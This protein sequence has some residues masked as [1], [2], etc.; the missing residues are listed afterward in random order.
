MVPQVAYR[1]K[2]TQRAEVDYSYKKLTGGSGQFA[3]VKIVAEP[4]EPGVP[5]T[6]ENA[7]VG[8]TVPKKFIPG[9]EKGG[10][11]R[12]SRRLPRGRSQSDS[13]RRCLS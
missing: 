8:G 5:F 7:I 3:R 1:E 2:I 13:G 4:T 9:V 10:E 12:H 11:C 6:F